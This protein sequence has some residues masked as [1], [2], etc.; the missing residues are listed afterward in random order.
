MQILYLVAQDL[1]KNAH[2]RKFKA[3]F[4]TG[5]HPKDDLNDE[6]KPKCPSKPKRKLKARRSIASHETE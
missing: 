1:D 5:L 4:L 6:S 2:D 3:P